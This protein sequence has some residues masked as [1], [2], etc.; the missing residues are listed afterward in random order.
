VSPSDEDSG[1]VCLLSVCCL[2]AACPPH[3]AWYG[4]WCRRRRL[5]CY[6]CHLR[7][8]AEMPQCPRTTAV[9]Q[10]FAGRAFPITFQFNST[11]DFLSPLNV[12][13][14][15]L[16]LPSTPCQLEYHQ[17]VHQIAMSRPAALLRNAARQARIAP[18]SCGLQT[19]LPRAGSSTTKR[20]LSVLRSTP[21]R[22]TLVTALSSRP[23]ASS[24]GELLRRS[25]IRGSS[26]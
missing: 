19:P 4:A 22:S 5:C 7:G 13:R 20:P 11:R 26:P 18:S 23:F 15:P 6:S 9:W 25:S 17:L 2:S 14:H 10:A 24:S 3:G 8:R 21:A 1:Y 16:S 12:A